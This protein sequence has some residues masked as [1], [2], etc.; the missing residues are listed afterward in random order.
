SVIVVDRTIIWVFSKRRE[1]CPLFAR[2]SRFQKTRP[3]L[4]AILHSRH[5]DEQLIP[6]NFHAIPV[7]KTPL[8]TSIVVHVRKLGEFQAPF[9]TLVHTYSPSTLPDLLISLTCYPIPCLA[10]QTILEYSKSCAPTSFGRLTSRAL[11]ARRPRPAPTPAAHRHAARPCATSRA[12]LPCS[13]SPLVTRSLVPAAPLLFLVG[14]C[15]EPISAILIPTRNMIPVSFPDLPRI[16]P[17]TDLPRAFR[18]LTAIPIPARIS[19]R[20]LPIPTRIRHAA[21]FLSCASRA[22]PCAPYSSS[23][24]PMPTRYRPSPASHLCA[25]AHANAFA[26]LP[27][28]SS[29]ACV[30]ST[31]TPTPPRHRPRPLPLHA[32]LLAYPCRMPTSS[33]IRTPALPVHSRAISRSSPIPT[34][35]RASQPPAPVPCTPAAPI[36]PVCR[37]SIP[38]GCSSGARVSSCSVHPR[39]S[40]ADA[41]HSL[42]IRSP[43]TFLSQGYGTHF[44]I[45]PLLFETFLVLKDLSTTIHPSGT[46]SSIMR[47]SH[48]RSSS[49]SIASS[50]SVTSNSLTSTSMCCARRSRAHVLHLTP[51]PTI[52]YS[53][54]M[55]FGSSHRSSTNTE[56]RA[57]ACDARGWTEQDDTR[58]PGEQPTGIDNRHTGETG[59]AGVHGTGTGDWDARGM[60]GSGDEREIARECTGSAGVL[61]REGVGVLQGCARSDACKGSRRG[62]CLGGVGVMVDCTH[63]HEEFGGS[64]ANA[65]AC[66]W[67]HECDAGDG[68][69]TEV[70]LASGE[71][72]EE[73][74]GKRCASALDAHEWANR[75]RTRVWRG[76]RGRKLGRCTGARGDAV[77]DMGAG[78]GWDARGRSRARAKARELGGSADVLVRRGIGQACTDAR[79]K[80]GKSWACAVAREWD[81][82]D[83]ALG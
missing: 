46:L 68:L 32:S 63:A 41:R 25:H 82:A 55:S 81:D 17:V 30:Q 78:D 76:K 29:C 24:T 62:L 36:S 56:W 11:C 9:A 34:I 14:L 71:S 53:A 20:A 28:N 10:L 6:A 72:S 8:V 57:S 5:A 58:A 18:H 60:V 79:E 26:Q 51:D 80:D 61:I 73:R 38:V 48:S 40:Q 42:I 13:P 70:A 44:R 7:A 3:F 52:A 21:L 23:S 66:A 37:L 1:L 22:L 39:A 75:P 83:G 35:P 54:S 2:L 33:R 31:I 77:G 69:D 15:F 4:P 12:S 49:T 50:S 64:W 45:I 16:T 65:L 59:A 74:K 27:P 47:T 19:I 67:A 43:S